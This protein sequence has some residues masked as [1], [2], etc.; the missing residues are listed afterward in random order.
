MDCIFHDLD[1]DW[2]SESDA[3][4]DPGE[5]QKDEDVGVPLQ[6]LEQ[7]E[8]FAGPWILNT[9]TLVHKALWIAERD[10]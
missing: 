6:K 8:A 7:L 5:Q 9:V 10:W 4:S 1:S 3:S 2:D